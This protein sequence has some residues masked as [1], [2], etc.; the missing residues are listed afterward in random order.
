MMSPM[1]H[2]IPGI[3]EP[4][5]D[6]QPGESRPPEGCSIYIYIYILY[7]YIYRERERERCNLIY[8]IYI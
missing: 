2:A 7:I 4:W 5:S 8:V 6:C 3:I 1:T